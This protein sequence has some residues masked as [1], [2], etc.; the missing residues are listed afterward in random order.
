M[1]KDVIGNE[2]WIVHYREE[3]YAWSYVGYFIYLD[4]KY[5]NMEE[6]SSLEKYIHES[7]FISRHPDTDFLPI[8][9]AKRVEKDVEEEDDTTLKD[10]VN[11]LRKVLD[12]MQDHGMFEA[13]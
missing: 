11:E 5:T 10:D 6:M 8:G 1:P 2:D 12:R 4:E 13:S 3:H 9:T 7:V